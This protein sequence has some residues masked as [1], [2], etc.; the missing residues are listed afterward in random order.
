MISFNEHLGADHL[1]F[2][3]V[4]VC[5]GG[6]GGGWG[7]GDSV[8]VRIFFSKP[9]VIYDFFPDIQSHCVA[10]IPRKIFFSPE[11]STQDI[12]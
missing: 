1:L 9:L 6:G 3:C 10:G 12:L 2:E 8:C 5:G 11:I 4:C 7:M